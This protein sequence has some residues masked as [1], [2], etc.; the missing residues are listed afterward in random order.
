MKKLLLLLT[1]GLVVFVAIYRQ[2]LFLRDPV[3]TVSRDGVKQGDVRVMINYTNDILLDDASTSTRKLYLVQNWNKI[4]GGPTAPLKCFAG[5][6]CMTDADQ[7]S[8]TPVESGSRGKRSAF[9]GVTMTS[10]RIEFV[11]EHGA[12]VEVTLR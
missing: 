4:A 10:K 7:A 2:R 5:L 11:D 8:A 6:V 1:L 9:E 3:A 12:L